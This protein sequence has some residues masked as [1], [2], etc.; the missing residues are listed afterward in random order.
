[1]LL[2]HD[3]FIGISV[4]S[5]QTGAELAHT[6]RVIIDPRDLTV[7]AYELEGPM[8]NEHPSFLRVADIRELS[9]IGFI[10]DSSDEFVGIDDVIKLKEVYE[11]NFELIGLKVVDKK[12]RKL[13]KVNG[14]TVDAGNFV[15]QQIGVK[16]PL[17]QSFNETE[18][19]INRTQI[20]EVSN[21]HV[22]VNSAEVSTANRQPVR[23]YSNPFR[24]TTA[25][26]EAIDSSAPH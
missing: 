17:V 2:S 25:Q 5:L 1:M 9:T 11:F 8:L 10:I 15:V 20:V 14:Y 21:E 16:R 12:D 23:A 22:I 4:M 13:G 6:K 18:L 19:L 3:R 26:P 7:V 24:Q